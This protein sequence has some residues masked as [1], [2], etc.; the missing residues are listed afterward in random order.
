MTNTKNQLSINEVKSRVLQIITYMSETDRQKLLYLIF[1][2]QSESENKKSLSM[3]ITTLP[4]SILRDLWGQLEEWHKFKLREMRKNPR[5]PTF[6]STECSIGDVCFT[7]FIQD[8]SAGGVFI[9]SDGNFFIGQDLT[10]TFS[11]PKSE[12]EINISGEVV[13]LDSEGIGVK[14][15]EPIAVI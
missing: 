14:F 15:N 7:D 13:R 5:K 8:I 3:L 12:E 6:I 10:L 11:L 1:A 4:E 9:R 2:T